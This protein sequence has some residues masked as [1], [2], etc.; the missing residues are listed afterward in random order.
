MANVINRLRT[1]ASL[2]LITALWCWL[3]TVL[4]AIWSFG[5]V[6][7]YLDGGRIPLHPSLPVTYAS[8][9][10]QALGAFAITF[11]LA[12]VAC[13][14]APRRFHLAI[15]MV[16]WLIGGYWG[17][18]DAAYYYQIDFGMTWRPHEAFRALFFH[19]IVTPFWI[20]LGLAGTASFTRPL[21]IPT[22]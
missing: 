7:G 16:I 14:A 10:M 4:H 5:I 22:K 13:T 3:L 8:F 2:A 9:L 17:A 20:G 6:L 15:L 18:T 11:I 21:R 19:P 1:A 12:L